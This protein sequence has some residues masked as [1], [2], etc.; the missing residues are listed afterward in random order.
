MNSNN[1]NCVEFA[2]ASKDKISAKLNGMTK[3]ERKMYF[4]DLRLKY[5]HLQREAATLKT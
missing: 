3:T 4:E 2:R 5:A 1:F